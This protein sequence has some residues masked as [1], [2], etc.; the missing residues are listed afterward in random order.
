[1]KNKF[2]IAKL[3]NRYKDIS[4]RM[5]QHR[6]LYLLILPAFI[7]VLIFKYVPLY[8]VQ[9]A[10]KE[11]KLGQ[12]INQ[13]KWVGW[14]NFIRFVTNGS[15]IRT[16][17]NTLAIGTL[18][19]LTFPLPI[20]LAVLLHNCEVKWV[21]KT[22]QTVTYIP[23][24][25]SVVVTMSIVMLFCSDSTGFINIFLKKFGMET[26][27]FFSN[28]KYVYP[29]Y[30][31]SGIWSSIGY[32]AVIYLASL[33]TVNQDIVDAAVMDGCSKLQRIW[34]VDL[35]KI[36]PTIITIFIMNMG[37]ILGLSTEKMLLLQTDLN[38]AASEVIGT[39]TYKVGIISRQYGYS[40]AVGLCTNLVSFILI[41]VANE[42][43]KR[44]SNTSLF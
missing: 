11:L 30:I 31:I 10:W 12:S 9:L 19:L 34:Y 4:R 22:V 24:L 25:V 18:S 28:E 39:Y 38:L 43:A 16:L 13:A 7:I 29:M 2:N 40:T 6:G 32:N 8:G 36:R 26:I 35:P 3:R 44:V 21:K 23:N 17:K 42:I 14:D 27:P 20:I 41:C 33:S 1:M 5:N 15:F 37:S